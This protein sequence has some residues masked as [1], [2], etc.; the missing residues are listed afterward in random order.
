MS[1]EARGKSKVAGVALCGFGRAGQIHFGNLRSNYRCNLKYIVDLKE[2][3]VQK[4]IADTL[5]KYNVT[6]ITLVGVE[7]FEEVRSQHSTEHFLF[8]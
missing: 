6:S 3:A 4:R 7:D 2:P 8:S 5:D 1:S